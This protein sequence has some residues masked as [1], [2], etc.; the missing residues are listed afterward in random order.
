MLSRNAFMEKNEPRLFNKHF[1][2]EV[3]KGATRFHDK[4]IES[5]SSRENLMNFYIILKFKQTSEGLRLAS[6]WD[7]F[8]PSVNIF[9]P[10]QFDKDYYYRDTIAN[11]QKESN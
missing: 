3:Q 7:H 2:R 11:W 9:D 1:L 8:D 4:I 6:Y 5:I 10:F